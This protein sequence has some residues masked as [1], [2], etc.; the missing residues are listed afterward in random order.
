MNEGHLNANFRKILPI[1]VLNKEGVNK[2]FIYHE[3][4]G[5]I[6]R[7]ENREER[8]GLIKPSFNNHDM[9]DSMKERVNQ[10]SF[11]I[12]CLKFKIFKDF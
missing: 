1:E 4:R 5:Y 2:V 11:F 12:V 3:D 9:F 10:V 6:M 8:E 7:I